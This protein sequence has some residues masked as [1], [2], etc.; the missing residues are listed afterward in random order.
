MIAQKWDFKT[1]TYKPYNTPDTWKCPLT[2]DNMDEDINCSN[3]GKPVKF[4]NCFTSLAI[5]TLIGFGYPVCE[6]CYEAELKAKD[7]NKR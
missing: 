1:H 4:G 2:T 6:T 5:H 3:C 7:E